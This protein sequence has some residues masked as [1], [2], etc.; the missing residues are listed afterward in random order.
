MNA[1]HTP[2]PWYAIADDAV[3][4]VKHHDIRSQDGMSVAY[5]FG[6]YEGNENAALI[7]AAPDLLA[8]LR[9]L[10]T[11]CERGAWNS[12][13]NQGGHV[14]AARAAIAKATGA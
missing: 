6:R 2:G 7:A 3:H 10:V 13:A 1:K 8:A 5:A 4:A 14:V 11:A 9:A 12:E